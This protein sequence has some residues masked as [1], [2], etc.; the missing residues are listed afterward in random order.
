M[1]EDRDYMR[2]SF[3]SVKAQKSPTIMIIIICT[4]LYLADLFFTPETFK[5]NQSLALTFRPETMSAQDIA[6]WALAFVSNIFL[7][8]DFSHILW[9]MIGLFIFGRILERHIKTGDFYRLFICSGLIS[10][11]VFILWQLVRINVFKQMPNGLLGASGAIYSLLIAMLLLMPNE[12]LYLFLFGRVKVKWLILFYIAFDLVGALLS[13]GSKS[14]ISH[15]A[16]FGG[17]FGGWL[18]ITIFHS[19]EVKFKLNDIK[20]PKRGKSKSK[21]QSSSRKFSANYEPPEL[22]LIPAVDEPEEEKDVMLEID[23]ILDKIGKHGLKSLTKEERRVLDKAK[24][25]LD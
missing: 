22:D 10:C 19:K 12:Q 13:I 25:Q 9:N 24:D 1:L 11:V 6:K 21:P 17:M 5:L 2:E 16:H 23:P 14:Q 4:V 18:M 3:D 20:P 15:V 7:H 8:K